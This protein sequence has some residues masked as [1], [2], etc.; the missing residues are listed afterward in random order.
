[1]IET[2]LSPEIRTQRGKTILHR[3]HPLILQSH[4]NHSGG[5]CDDKD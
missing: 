3:T 2:F 4:H 1:M 5:E